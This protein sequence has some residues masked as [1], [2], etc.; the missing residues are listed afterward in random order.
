MT[1]GI[2]DY[3]NEEGLYSSTWK[4]VRDKVFSDSLNF[5]PGDAWSYSNTN[6]WMAARIIEKITGMDYNQYL[7]Q[8][9]FSNICPTMT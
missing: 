8:N 5:K 7:E 1:S 3:I 6:F 9:F 2:K 4:S